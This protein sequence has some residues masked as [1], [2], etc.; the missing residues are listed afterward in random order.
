[1]RF[2]IDE[3]A[4]LEEIAALPG[5]EEVNRE[6][7]AA[8]L[9]EAAR[10]AGEVLSPLNRPGDQ[11]VASLSA[12]GVAAAAGFGE[13]YGRF[14]DNGWNGLSGDPEY[15][16]QGLPGLVAAAAIEMWNSANTAFALCPLL[17][18]GA[19]EAI[20]THAGDELK[21]RYLE[22]LVSGEWTG[23]MNLTEPQ[24]GSDLSAVRTR[25][26]PHGDHYPLY[27][28]KIFITWGASGRILIGSLRGPT[29][30]RQKPARPQ[31]LGYRLW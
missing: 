22:R 21:S 27:G 28:Q 18:A 3:L 30:C 26:V 10:L 7:V 13:A 12:D 23:T 4:G 24:A 20:S 29:K 15:G 19:T 2:V 1:M 11:S 25:A 31:Q 5:W 14:V 9:D 8:V 6:L 17:T 16:G